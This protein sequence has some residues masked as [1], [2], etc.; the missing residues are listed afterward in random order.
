VD[1]DDEVLLQEVLT[2]EADED[3]EALDEWYLY[4]QKQ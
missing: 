2:D 3:D 4:V 1:E